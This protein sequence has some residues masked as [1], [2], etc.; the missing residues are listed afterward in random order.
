MT[1]LGLICILEIEMQISHYPQFPPAYALLGSGSW[2]T[3]DTSSQPPLPPK[4]GL[5]AEVCSVNP[6][7]FG[8]VI[9]GVECCVMLNCPAAGKVQWQSLEAG[10]VYKSTCFVSMR[11][12]V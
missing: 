10:S 1:T 3:G 8:Q 9:H 7:H 5:G 11:T 6:R 12:G 2:V 4:G